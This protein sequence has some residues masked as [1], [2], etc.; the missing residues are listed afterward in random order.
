MAEKTKRTTKRKQPSI[1][2]KPKSR[3]K[4]RASRNFENENEKDVV[5]AENAESRISSNQND[6][7]KTS[8]LNASK[9]SEVN[10]ASEVSDLT[11]N[12]IALHIPF[13][14]IQEKGV[15]LTDKNFIQ[16]QVLLLSTPFTLEDCPQL[17]HMQGNKAERKNHLPEGVVQDGLKKLNYKMDDEIQKHLNRQSQRKVLDDLF[18]I[19]NEISEHDKQDDQNKINIKETMDVSEILRNCPEEWNHGE[20]DVDGNLLRRYSNILA[21]LKEMDDELKETQQ[22]IGSYKSSSH[23]ISEL[24]CLASES[25]EGSFKE[26]MARTRQLVCRIADVL[27]HQENSA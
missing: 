27:H 23:L 11:D 15:N 9:T 22:K 12:H 24:E 25:L 2:Y 6:V 1:C 3:K 17:V 4:G 21:E 18:E 20:E 5:E 7:S 13:E 19:E 26:E 14:S 8:T 16:Q 10:T